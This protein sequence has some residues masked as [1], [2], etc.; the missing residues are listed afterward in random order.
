MADLGSNGALVDYEVENSGSFGLQ[1]TGTFSATITFRSS[2][3]GVNFVDTGLTPISGGAVVTSATA[4]GLWRSS[5]GGIKLFRAIVTSYT[6][7]TA[8]VSCQRS[9]ET[10]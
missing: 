2:I 8:V 7:G 4:P 6:S 1:I 3:D 5:A 10:V 9:R